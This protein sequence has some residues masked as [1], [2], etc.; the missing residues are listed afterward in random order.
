MEISRSTTPLF[1]EGDR[2]AGGAEWIDD[3]QQLLTD[4]TEA[5][6]VI[7]L[8]TSSVCN[9]T[10]TLAQLEDV[11]TAR[12]QDAGVMWI[13]VRQD[14][15]PTLIKIGH[16]LNI[17]PLTIDDWVSESTQLKA[18][19]FD[20]FVPSP[21]RIFIPLPG[22]TRFRIDTD[23]Q[24]YCDHGEGAGLR[25]QHQ[26]PQDRG[27]RPGSDVQINIVV[28]GNLVLTVHA[29]LLNSVETLLAKVH[30]SYACKIPS[31]HWLFYSLL[32][33]VAQRYGEILRQLQEDVETLQ[34]LTVLATSTDCHALL[35]R[36]VLCKT[37]TSSFSGLVTPRKCVASVR[38]CHRGHG[39][40][41]KS[42]SPPGSCCGTSSRRRRCSS[43]SRSRRTCWT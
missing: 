32:M 41:R 23:G 7:T 34:Q 16:L 8:N 15:E 10:V 43:R 25:A 9:A 33:L 28:M 22:V 36:F 11:L 12:T 1:N 26:H 18:T 30:S 5:S 4:P 21:S 6:C 29:T 35:N 38:A 31:V 42:S 13:D 37:R 27:R 17:H 14:N 3:Y 24:I 2:A 20:T 19:V 39:P 40:P